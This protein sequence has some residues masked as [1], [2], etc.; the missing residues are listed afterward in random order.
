MSPVARG[1][2]P[3]SP[4]Y[5]RDSTCADMAHTLVVVIQDPFL[6][7]CNQIIPALRLFKAP[8]SHPSLH[9]KGCFYQILPALPLLNLFLLNP[10][11]GVDVYGAVISKHAAMIT[12]QCL[13][14]SMLANSR[15]EYCNV[16]LEV[17]S[18]RHCRGEDGSRVAL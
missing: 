5:E 13:W 2:A 10:E 9:I 14:T 12:D 4:F 8:V 15:I 11:S 7:R 18:A 16:L 17:L 3:T 1:I 6:V